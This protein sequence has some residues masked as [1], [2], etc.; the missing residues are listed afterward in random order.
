MP[1]FSASKN[2]IKKLS[3][4]GNDS[5]VRFLSALHVTLE[6]DKETSTVTLTRTGKFWD[7]RYGDFEIGR[8]ML[9]EMV[10]NF[11]NN[12]YGQE[13]F[14]DESH[15]P[16]K[17]AAGKIVKLM[18]A[19]NRLRALVEWTPFG[20]DAIKKRGFR[21]LSAEFNENFVDSETKKNHGVVLM[22][23][24][25]TIRPV[26]KRL[27]PV[28]LSESTDDEQH[29]VLLHPELIKQLSE[30]M[31]L[32]MNKFK[33]LLLEK[34][35]AFQLSESHSQQLIASFDTVAKHLGEDE[36]A[37]A[38]LVDEYEKSAKQLSEAGGAGDV[39]LTI[40]VPE[41]K[42]DG[43]EKTLSEED[44]R[45]ILKKDRDD[46]AAAAKKL[47]EGLETN[48]TLFNTLIDEAEGLKTLSEEQR[49]NIKDA[50]D[51]L[52][53]EMSEAQV[54]KLAEHQI[55]LGNQMSVQQQLAAMGHQGPAGSV[56][57]SVDSS[58][59]IK[60]LQ[61]TAD[62]RFGLNGLSDAVRFERT[63]G[64]LRNENKALAD[65]VLAMYDQAHGQRLAAEHKMLA[66]GDGVVADVA[67]PA[68]FERTVI[69]EALY[70]LVGLQFVNVG[71]LPFAS[72][73]LI[74]YSYRDITAAGINNARVYQGGSIPRSGVKQ[75]SETAYPIPQK[76]SFEV[77]DE[78]RYLTSSGILNWEAVAENQRNATRIIAEDLE[79]MIFNEV[80][81]SA[82]EEGAVAIGSAD[83]FTANGANVVF[84]LSQFPVVRPRSVFD[85]NGAQVGST[86]NPIVVSY[87]SVDRSEYDG[88][89]QQAAGTYYVLNYNQGEIYFVDETGTLVVPPNTTAISV[90]YSYS[91]NVGKFDTDLGSDTS[92]IHW[93]DFLYR[94]GLRKSV[95]EDQRYH[96]A[97][98]GLMSGT[99][100]TQVEQAKK[101][102]A[103]S[104]RPGTDLMADGNLGRIKDVPNYKTSAPG[105]WMG[106]ER[107]I[108][109]ERGQTRL[110]M[111]KPWT[112]G[113]L[114]NQKDA[115]G[116]FTGKKEAY[117]DQFLVLHTP[118]QL[119]RAY[120]SIVMYSATGRVTRA[121]L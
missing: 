74:P 58:N 80:L 116:R 49:K 93:D 95:I 63:G 114:E 89:G 54:R 35:A 105:L 29:R 17:G 82:D 47:S 77:S 91:T 69:R 92:E 100:M 30:E 64:V 5:S 79:A 103:N 11:D 65:K 90:D 32:T 76:I 120:T 52:T 7:R 75:E 8:E 66:G 97:N 99:A 28:E 57:I 107:S 50:A 45:S 4:I 60:S 62:N 68:V 59:S 81:H 9:L 104:K 112:M 31:E 121:A 22:G 55:K 109:G 3:N 44:I 46:I 20:V 48:T 13:I 26:I 23:A 78:L 72:S 37:L 40:N 61:E 67:V 21:Y 110:R 41:F 43:D 111:M 94:F 53:S 70:S 85:L 88:T 113:E 2:S 19:G 51:L 84:A 117:G 12:A 39:T 34:L 101:F 25:L 71:T 6:E 108:I 24:G 106:D 38:S 15:D 83:T 16:K 27:D 42:N 33:K 87:A 36:K 73:A 14:I 119:K 86:Q 56:H 10:K 98:F 118:T 18:V 1:D 102:G 96:N 115:N